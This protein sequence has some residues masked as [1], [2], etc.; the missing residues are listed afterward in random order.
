MLV[1]CYLDRL[2]G[3]KVYFQNINYPANTAKITNQ[4]YIIFYIINVTVI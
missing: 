1:I 2:T 4:N 3:L